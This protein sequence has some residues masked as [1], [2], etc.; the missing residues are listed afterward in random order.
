M[1]SFTTR[2]N[3]LLSVSIMLACALSIA[4]SGELSVWAKGKLSKDPLLKQAGEYFRKNQNDKA[5]PLFV[6]YLKKNPEDGEARASL[7]W[8]IFQTRFGNKKAVPEALKE[9]E[10]AVKQAPKSP[11]AHNVLGAIYFS[12]G[13]V[14]EAQKEF[15][16]VIAID[17]KRKCGGCGD[18]SALL[19]VGTDKDKTTGVQRRESASS[20][21][22]SKGR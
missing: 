8:I 12:Q 1:S 13:R 6:Q 4:F 22:N 7:A 10:L 15:R 9:A 21:R 3:S 16:T 19:N 11:L 18:F 5:H 14:P 2:L 20:G 17:P